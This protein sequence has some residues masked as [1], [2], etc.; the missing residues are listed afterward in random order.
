MAIRFCMDHNLPVAIAEQL[1]QRG[2]DLLFALEDDAQELE[3]T[4]LLQRATSLGRVIVT[5]DADFL[6]IADDW[7]H[8]GREFPGIIYAHLLRNQIGQ[9]IADLELIA[10]AIE[11]EEINSQVIYLPLK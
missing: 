4:P 6:A 5:Q 3:D 11:Q 10:L 2:V 1:R 7:Q 9:I 8:S